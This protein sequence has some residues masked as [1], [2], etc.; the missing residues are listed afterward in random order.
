MTG[1]QTCAL[2]ILSDVRLGIDMGIIKSVGAES[3]NQIMVMMQPAFLQKNANKALSTNERDV[4]R[5][6]LVREKLGN[7]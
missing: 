2:P 7:N 5:A 4:R 6:S 1:V 3:L